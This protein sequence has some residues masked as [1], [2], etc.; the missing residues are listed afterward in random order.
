MAEKPELS[1]ARLLRDS[2]SSLRGSLSYSLS[3]LTFS[4]GGGD[5]TLYAN[6]SNDTTTAHAP[7]TLA[8][9]RGKRLLGLLG[10]SSC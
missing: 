4:P 10:L 6:H 8:C 3:T 1:S 5:L 7:P 9:S 2:L